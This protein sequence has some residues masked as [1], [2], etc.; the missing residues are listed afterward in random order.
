GLQ[1]NSAVQRSAYG[2]ERFNHPLFYH[3]TSSSPCGYGLEQTL[4]PSDQ[5]R[6]LFERCA[7]AF[8][9]RKGCCNINV[10]ESQRITDDEFTGREMGFQNF[11][12]VANI[13]HRQL[14]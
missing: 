9:L 14:D 1:T 11:C 12:S 2:A 4:L 10:C 6:E 5:V 13:G 3:F 7:S 8:V